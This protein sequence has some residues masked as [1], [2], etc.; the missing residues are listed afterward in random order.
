MPRTANAK[1]SARAE[2]RAAAD[3]SAAIAATWTDKNIRARRTERTAVKVGGETYASVGKAFEALGLP[4]TQM[5]RFRVLLKASASGRATFEAEN[6][7]KHKFT[8]VQK[9]E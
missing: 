2:K 4:T 5:V 3:R 1:T 9:A 8:V 6:G 7:A